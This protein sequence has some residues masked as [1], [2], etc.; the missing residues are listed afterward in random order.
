MSTRFLIAVNEVLEV[1][2][3][4]CIYTRNVAPIAICIPIYVLV[5]G[6]LLYKYTY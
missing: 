1:S 6:A 3:Y 2:N 5:F 4:A